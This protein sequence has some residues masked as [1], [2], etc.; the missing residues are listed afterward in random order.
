MAGKVWGFKVGSI[1]FTEKG[2]KVIEKILE[3]GSRIFL[4][5]KFHDIPNTVQLSVREA[6]RLGVQMLT[7]HA[8]G[9]RE[10]MIAAAREQSADTAV[11][12]VTI[13]TSLNNT[14][15]Q[16]LSMPGPIEERALHYASLSN[17][18][19]IKGIVCSPQEVGNIREK[20]SEIV[21]LTPG[22]RFTEFADDQKRTA[23]AADVFRAGA[24]YAVLGRALTDSSDWEK[25][26]EMIM[27]SLEGISFSKHLNSK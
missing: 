10:M 9:G 2:P 8:S 3:S 12:A 19:G 7:I 21:I 25:T 14:D 15:L 24:D 27:S 4:D 1:L 6:F 17:H 16:E 26:W 18:L 5:L 22:I 13:L 20:F 23:S 11:L